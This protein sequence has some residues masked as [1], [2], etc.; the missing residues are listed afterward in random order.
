[1]NI[2]SLIIIMYTGQHGT[3]ETGRGG[4]SNVAPG[5]LLE[6]IFGFVGDA[7]AEILK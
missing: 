6:V 4:P 1:M 5:R 3:I 2:N 7:P